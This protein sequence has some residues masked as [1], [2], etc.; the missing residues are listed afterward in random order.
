MCGHILIHLYKYKTPTVF[1]NSRPQQLLDNICLVIDGGR[2]QLM[3]DIYKCKKNCKKSHHEVNKSTP[4]T[5]LF[6]TGTKK[7]LLL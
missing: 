3:A 7:K 4:N 1:A 5:A 6:R 2:G